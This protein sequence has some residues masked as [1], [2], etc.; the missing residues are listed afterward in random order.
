MFIMVKCSKKK[1]TSLPELRQ[2]IKAV[3]AVDWL[4]ISQKQLKVKANLSLSIITRMNKDKGLTIIALKHIWQ[5]SD[6]N[7]SYTSLKEGFEAR[8]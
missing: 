6:H 4:D 5:V 8:C 7:G 2:A 3:E 1:L